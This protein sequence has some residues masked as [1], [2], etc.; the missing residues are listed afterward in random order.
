MMKIVDLFFFFFFSMSTEHVWMD[1]RKESQDATVERHGKSMREVLKFGTTFQQHSYK[2][3]KPITTQCVVGIMGDKEYHSNELQH[4]E[5]NR[6]TE[7][8]Y[9][10]GLVNEVR[11]N[12]KHWSSNKQVLS[13]HS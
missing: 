3:G 9:A 11:K 13:T 12:I 2:W 1:I 10:K 8:E 6:R 5:D 7:I 4:R